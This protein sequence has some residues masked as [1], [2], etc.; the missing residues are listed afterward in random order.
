MYMNE[1]DTHDLAWAAGFL[2][3]EGNF[4][5]GL[6]N[7]GTFYVIVQATN[8][9]PRPLLKLVAL[10]GG[11][12][13]LSTREAGS[14]AKDVYRYRLVKGASK[15]VRMLRPYL[16]VKGEHADVLLRMQDLVDG[17]KHKYAA[18]TDDELSARVALR[19]EIR[20]LNHR[21]RSA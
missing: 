10:F 5:I 14:R 15:V 16:V 2:D 11:K 9:D 17:R 19:T 21:G 1:I 4:D 12:S 7:H 6:N 13:R 8:V 20:A 18:L 3:G